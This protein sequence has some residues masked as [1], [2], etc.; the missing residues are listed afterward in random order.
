YVL[1]K[2]SSDS[3]MDIVHRVIGKREYFLNQ[4]KKYSCVAYV[5]GVQKLDRIPKSLMNPN[6][7][8][9]LSVD[10]TGKGMLYQ[11]ESLS[12][13]NFQLPNKVK[14]EM[15]ASKSFGRNA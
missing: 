13:Y 5:K 7:A 14:E 4:V 9:A 3:A 1:Q 15:I 12:N 8:D 2:F 11:S 10:S 6:V